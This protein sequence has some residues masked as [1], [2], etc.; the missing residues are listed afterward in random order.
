[1]YYIYKSES[2]TLHTIQDSEIDWNYLDKYSITMGSTVR[3]FTF[4]FPNLK[5]KSLK[6]LIELSQ[7]LVNTETGNEQTISVSTQAYF[8]PDQKATENAIKNPK[9]VPVAHYIN[10]SYFLYD[11]S[12]L[13]NTFVTALYKKIYLFT[14]QLAALKKKNRKR[15]IQSDISRRILRFYVNKDT[16]LFSCKWKDTNVQE[17]KKL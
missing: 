10:E 17:Q 11:K 14:V 1:M 15:N 9:N 12:D 8:F 6:D 3:G 5:K 4:T 7:D 16:K 2:T 13:I